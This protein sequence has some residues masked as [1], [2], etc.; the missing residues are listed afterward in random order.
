MQRLLKKSELAILKTRR[1]S[2]EMADQYEIPSDLLVEIVTFNPASCEW[3]RAGEL[4][5]VIQYLKAQG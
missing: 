5:S 4:G 3:S 2:F 1:E